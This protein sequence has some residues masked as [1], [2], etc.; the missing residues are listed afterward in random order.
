MDCTCMEIQQSPAA[1]RHRN[2]IV[3]YRRAGDYAIQ[4]L[5]EEVNGEL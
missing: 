5:R 2:R 3:N 4:A 1:R